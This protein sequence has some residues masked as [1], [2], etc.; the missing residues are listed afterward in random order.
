MT[1]QDNDTWF[2]RGKEAGWR[3]AAGMMLSEEFSNEAAG[4]TK[5]CFAQ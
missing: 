2:G 1:I 3:Q 5:S 4:M